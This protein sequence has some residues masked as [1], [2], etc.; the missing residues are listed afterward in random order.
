MPLALQVLSEPFYQDRHDWIPEGQPP[1][2]ISPVFH[3]HGNRWVQLKL[4]CAPAGAIL[5]RQMH[6][7][8]T[9][10]IQGLIFPP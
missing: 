5:Q 7:G 8:G 10:R 1:H 2:Y 9:G 6:E 4:S 3:Y